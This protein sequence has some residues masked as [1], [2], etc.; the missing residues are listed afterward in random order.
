MYWNALLKVQYNNC[1]KKESLF[2]I[3][4]ISY[5][6]IGVFVVFLVSN[7]H[8]YVDLN[9]N[10]C[11]QLLG[12]HQALLYV[13]YYEMISFVHDVY[14]LNEYFQDK[15]ISRGE[16]GREGDFDNIDKH[17]LYQLNRTQLEFH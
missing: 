13:F 8:L 2:G 9:H 11:L 15:N 16:H 14:L 5:L 3:H 6:I 10:S 4:T 12:N 7:H 17:Q 1:Q